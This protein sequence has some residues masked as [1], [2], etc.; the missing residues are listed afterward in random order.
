MAFFI[1]EDKK[2]LRSLSLLLVL[3]VFILQLSLAAPVLGAAKKSGNSPKAAPAQNVPAAKAGED[4]KTDFFQVHIPSGWI[5]PYPVKSRHKPDGTSAVFSNEKT[6]VTVT[7]NVVQT[8][9]SLKEF[10]N[11]IL[12]QMKASGLK[13]GMPV[14]EGGLNKIKISGMPQ[15]EAWFGSNGKFCTATVILSQSP[16]ISSANELL[17]VMKFSLPQLFPKKIK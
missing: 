5:M 10:S 13:P 6:H 9:F 14:M 15:G 1:N 12:S 4:V 17:S 7:F 11:T 2:M 3:A 8:P 16:N